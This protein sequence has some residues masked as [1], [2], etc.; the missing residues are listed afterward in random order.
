M[1]FNTAILT[2]AAEGSGTEKASFFATYGFSIIMI[3]ALLAFF[4]LF[5]LRPQKKQ[6]KEVTAMR[7]GLQVGDEV[8]TIGGIIGVIVSI[9]DETVT[10]ET[11]RDRARLRVLKN[12]I[13]SVDVPAQAAAEYSEKE[14]HKDK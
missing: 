3:V 4:Y 9:K 10:I 14:T 8:T 2:A 6:E 5:I 12:A 7:N 1:N 13:K 11:G